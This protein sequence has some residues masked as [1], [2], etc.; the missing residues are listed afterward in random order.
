VWLSVKVIF[1]N[2][3]SD[4]IKLLS[5][6]TVS[7]DLSGPHIW[8]SIVLSF[9]TL[10]GLVPDIRAPAGPVV[11]V[12]SGFLGPLNSGLQLALQFGFTGMKMS[13]IDSQVTPGKAFQVHLDLGHRLG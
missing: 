6:P 10:F 3:T 7:V 5:R 9:G 11:D 1:S 12:S 2:K 8:D 13:T 4:G